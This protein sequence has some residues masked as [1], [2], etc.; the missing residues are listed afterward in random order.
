MKMSKNYKRQRARQGRRASS[1]LLLSL[2]A[3]CLTAC[4]LLAGCSGSGRPPVDEEDAPL[5]TEA[6]SAGSPASKNAL[7]GVWR[8]ESGVMELS[9]SEDG[10]LLLKPLGG[11]SF[12]GSY[13]AEEG[14]LL[15]TYTVPFG[16]SL[17]EFPYS[18]SEDGT[19]LNM[20]SARY[21]RL[22]PSV[23]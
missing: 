7:A 16:R 6:A 8:D 18:L 17:E 11:P 2:L 19:V 10:S 20:G 3:A 13:S 9:L 21:E 5:H 23:S 12:S 1:A 15:L 22:R 14:S 4:L